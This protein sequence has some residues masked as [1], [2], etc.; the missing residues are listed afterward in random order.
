[1]KPF[2]SQGLGEYRPLQHESP[3][4]P[5][6][7][8]PSR[9]RS[10][11]P[12]TSAWRQAPQSARR[13]PSGYGGS[14]NCTSSSNQRWEPRPHRATP[15]ANRQQRDQLSRTSKPGYDASTPETLYVPAGRWLRRPQQQPPRQRRRRQPRLV[16]AVW[17]GARCSGS[18]HREIAAASDAGATLQNQK[19]GHEKRAGRTPRAPCR[20]SRSGPCMHANAALLVRQ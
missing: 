10:R 3:S 14:G 16:P 1:M 7:Q 6:L 4:L 15:K 18:R 17:R 11:S 13:L 19:P 12:P 8:P 20:R 5:A 9:P 2:Q